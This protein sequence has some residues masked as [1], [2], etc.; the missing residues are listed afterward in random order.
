ME[1]VMSPMDFNATIAAAANLPYEQIL[2][3]P[4]GRPFKLADKGE[5]VKALLA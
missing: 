2:V 5:P 1:N 3:S 4:Q